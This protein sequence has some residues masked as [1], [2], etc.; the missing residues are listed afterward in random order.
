MK[1]TMIIVLG[2]VLWFLIMFSSF[3]IHEYYHKFDYRNIETT[4]ENVCVLFNCES[5]HLGSYTFDL[6][7]DNDYIDVLKIREYTEYK[8]YLIQSAYCLSC[9]LII[10]LIFLKQKHL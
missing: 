5:G 6:I 10:L 9:F 4:N 1:K 7:N 3:Y 2:I 8:A